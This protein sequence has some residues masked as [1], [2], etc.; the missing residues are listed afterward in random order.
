MGVL[1]GKDGTMSLGGTAIP[2]IRDIELTRSRDMKEYASSDTSGHFR[3]NAGNKRWSAT[4]NMYVDDGD[5]TI[6]NTAALDT[7]YENDTALEMIFTTTTGKTATGNC[8]IGEITV[9][10]DIE[11]AENIAGTIS[12]VCD[13]ALAIT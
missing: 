6:G 13:G 1:T 4:C 10:V 11:N 9:P 3:N 2:E 5:L 8:K 12:L 7:A